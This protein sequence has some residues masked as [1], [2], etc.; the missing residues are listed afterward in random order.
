MADGRVAERPMFFANVPSV[1][2]PSLRVDGGHVFSLEALYT[3]YRLQGGWTASG[4]P[5]RWLEVY[6]ELRR[7]RASST[8][9]NAGGR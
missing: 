1:L 3:P 9:S 6:A 7:S 4:S 2:D 8:A 5:Q